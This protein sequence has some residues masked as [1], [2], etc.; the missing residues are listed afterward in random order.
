MHMAHQ[1][2]FIGS[3]FG[4]LSTVHEVRKRDAQADI[5]LIA[6]TRR[7]ALPAG[8][9]LDSLWPAHASAVH[10]SFGKFLYPYAR[11]ARGC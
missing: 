9:H 10:H 1:I 4:V 8:L 3:G 2:T 11:Q 6:P 5:T 7:T